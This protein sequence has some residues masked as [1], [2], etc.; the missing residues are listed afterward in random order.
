MSEQQNQAVAHMTEKYQQEL[1]GRNGAQTE[2][3][4]PG[5]ERAE[6][7]ARG[8]G[9][10]KASTTP[11]AQPAGRPRHAAGEDDRAEERQEGGQHEHGEREAQAEDDGVG[12]GAHEC[13]HL[14]HRHGPPNLNPANVGLR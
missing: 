1:A 13:P 12:S 5:D 6:G 2:L 9:H 4:Q 14:M 7:A 11:A 3:D 8:L 10:P